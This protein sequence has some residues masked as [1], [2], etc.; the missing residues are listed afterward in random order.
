LVPFLE[1]PQSGPLT[2]IGAG[3]EAAVF[4]DPANQQVIKLCGPHAC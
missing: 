1:R 4:F 3:G 2:L